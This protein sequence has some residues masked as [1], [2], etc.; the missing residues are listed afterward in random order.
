LN[1]NDGREARRTLSNPRFSR[2]LASR[3]AK[4]QK[5][6]KKRSNSNGT[7]LQVIIIVNLKIKKIGSFSLI[8]R[9]ILS[10]GAMLIFSVSFQIDLV[11][12]S[13]SN[14]NVATEPLTKCPE[15][16]SIFA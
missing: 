1:V 3:L 15:G 13:D 10:A 6:C 2:I 11:F 5:N 8:E 4:V 9:V 7:T 16:R 12:V 14:L